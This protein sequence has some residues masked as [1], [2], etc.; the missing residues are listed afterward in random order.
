MIVLIHFHKN[1]SYYI[2]MLLSAPTST[3]VAHRNSQRIVWLARATDP[4][5]NRPEMRLIYELPIRTFLEEGVKFTSEV[6]TVAL[7]STVPS[8]TNVSTL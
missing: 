6:C 7:M 3:L 2:R 8:L 4:F 5:L 1:A